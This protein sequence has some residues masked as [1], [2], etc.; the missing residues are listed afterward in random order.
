[1]ETTNKETKT[2]KEIKTTSD[3]DMGKHVN[4]KPRNSDNKDE[5][6]MEENNEIDTIE[7]IKDK[8]QELIDKLT[9]ARSIIS[10]LNCNG[11]ASLISS[12]NS[13]LNSN[14]KILE[15]IS[16]SDSN[17]IDDSLFN[18]ILCT[19]KTSNANYYYYLARVIENECSNKNQ[20]VAL[21]KRIK[22]VVN[23]NIKSKNINIISENGSK[24]IKIRSA[25][26]HNIEFDIDKKNKLLSEARN[27]IQL[28]K[29][30]DNRILYKPPKIYYFFHSISDETASELGRMGIIVCRFNYISV[31][32]DK[33]MI[34][35]IKEGD[36]KS[37]EDVKDNVL[38]SDSKIVDV[39]DPKNISAPNSDSGLVNVHGSGKSILDINSSDKSKINVNTSDKSKINVNT[40]DKSGSVSVPP[41]L[42]PYK[43]INLDV[44]CLIATVSND[45]SIEKS[46]I[47]SETSTSTE[48]KKSDIEIPNT[49]LQIESNIINNIGSEEVKS[50]KKSRKIK[51]PQMV[52]MSDMILED[53][54]LN[55]LFGDFSFKD[56][57]NFIDCKDIKETRDIK[58][59]MINGNEDTRSVLNIGN[60]EDGNDVKDKKDKSDGDRDDKDNRNEDKKD[61]DN[62]DKNRDEDKKDKVDDKNNRDNKY[63]NIIDYITNKYNKDDKD[64][65]S[66]T[67]KQAKIA[68][69]KIKA[70]IARAKRRELSKKKTKLDDD[71]PAITEIFKRLPSTL[72]LIACRTAMDLF[73]DIIKN[74][75]TKNEK[76]RAIHL[77]KKIT[78]VDDNPTEMFKELGEHDTKKINKIIFGT[79]DYYRAL[80]IT[81]NEKLI[82]R[83]ETLGYSIFFVI[84]KRSS[85]D[86]RDDED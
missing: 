23:K 67:L 73:L 18:T 46:F 22:T 33:S 76:I 7:S 28:A 13:H 38:N 81:S 29:S 24:W 58:C 11:S 31:K 26:Q 63:N 49:K 48:T 83:V 53:N 80:N 61:I 82:Y 66:N 41:T 45:T 25:S 21:N 57:K 85:F 37:K 30:P 42:L 39:Y 5:D 51:S 56:Y 84:S 86:T 55:K 78:I 35:D 64:E 14:I 12:I 52:R 36:I 75:A 62:E 9:Y 60:V 34:D 54:M 72:T 8:I 6:D 2:S 10:T 32:E 15:T 79:G 68:R 44:T 3:L 16:A 69:A 19:I 71:H 17:V 20:I 40:S 4:K 74:C 27:I 43:F 50:K 47:K 70:K 77:I 59:N 65:S 1:M